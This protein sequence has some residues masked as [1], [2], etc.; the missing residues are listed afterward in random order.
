MRLK[1]VVA[2]LVPVLAAFGMVLVAPTS[3]YAIGS[4]VVT[5]ADATKCGS[6]AA[7][8]KA[9]CSL[10][11]VDGWLR[12]TSPYVSPNIHFVPNG[13]W[14]I[15]GFCQVDGN[16]AVYCPVTNY[17]AIGE[18][19][20]AAGTIDQLIVI[21][22]HEETHY[23]QAKYNGAFALLT[24]NEK[25][26]EL[27]ADCGSGAASKYLLDQGKVSSNIAAVA[28]AIFALPGNQDPAH[29][30]AAERTASFNKGFQQG[31]L[32]CNSVSTLKVG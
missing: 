25:A 10:G 5:T 28:A 19:P 12:A 1:R 4:I 17:I 6:T 31:L 3:A 29:G 27:Q 18:T 2:A 26:R 16:T 24:A 30:T 8:D 13:A 9:R 23:R 22:A 11:I 32:S 20:A 15:D 21:L 14:A 7:I